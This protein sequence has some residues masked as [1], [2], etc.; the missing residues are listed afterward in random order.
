MFL[1]KSSVEQKINNLFFKF[2]GKSLIKLKRGRVP[3]WILS[4]VS[5]RKYKNFITFTLKNEVHLL[6][7][8]SRYFFTV[9]AVEW[10]SKY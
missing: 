3:V 6:G 10:L 7:E 9:S 5:Y 8:K 2:V 1:E 4:G